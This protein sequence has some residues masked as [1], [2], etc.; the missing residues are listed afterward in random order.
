MDSALLGRAKLS[1]DF[2]YSCGETPQHGDDVLPAQ[3]ERTLL[4]SHL[5]G[6]KCIALRRAERFLPTETVQ[7]GFIVKIAKSLG[8]SDCHFGRSH[9][10]ITEHSR[11]CRNQPFVL[12]HD[13]NFVQG[14]NGCIPSLVRFERFDRGSFALGK[15][16]FSFFAVNSASRIDHVIEGVEDWKVSIGIRFFAIALSQA[17]G[18]QVQSASQR[19]ER[20][21]EPSVEGEGQRDFLDCHHD[22]AN[23]IRI[24]LSGDDVRITSL[25][26]DQSLLDQWDLGYGPIDGSLSI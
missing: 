11:R 26:F 8:A 1:D 24:T 2:V 22:I 10:H 4:E 3:S 6:E 5:K 19:I 16:L 17:G 15:P 21:A 13:I 20:G 9:N 25:P 14:P 18:E 23:S 7:D 12:S